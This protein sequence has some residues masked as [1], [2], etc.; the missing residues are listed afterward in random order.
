MA[1]TRSASTQGKGQDRGGL[2]PEMPTRRCWSVAGI[3]GQRR[4]RSAVRALRVAVR[5]QHTDQPSDLA[6]AIIGP[7]IQV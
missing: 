6:V 4:D 2:A 7:E 1:A 3:P 5:T